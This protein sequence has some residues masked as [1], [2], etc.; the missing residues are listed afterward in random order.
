MQPALSRNRPL[1]HA[2]RPAA[3]AAGEPQ[4][5]VEPLPLGAVVLRARFLAQGLKHRTDRG[6]ALGVRSPRRTPV[7]PNVV[8]S[9]TYRSP[10]SGRSASG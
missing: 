10:G 4:C 8:P 3:E 9:W 5:V 1:T 7:P 6:G 2:S